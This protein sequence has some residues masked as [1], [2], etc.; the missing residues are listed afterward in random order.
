MVAVAS[1][2]QSAIVSN[3]RNCKVSWNLAVRENHNF[4]S[5]KNHHYVNYVIMTQPLLPPFLFSTIS[6]HENSSYRGLRMALTNMKW[7]GGF[8]G[9]LVG[10]TIWHFWKSQFWTTLCCQKFQF[11]QKIC[12]IWI[13]KRIAWIGPSVLLHWHQKSDA[14]QQRDSKGQISSL[15]KLS[16]GPCILTVGSVNNSTMRY[17]FFCQFYNYKHCWR[18]YVFKTILS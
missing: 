3:C 4:S 2:W 16:R 7:P 10:S 17:V 1:K 8:Q 11:G 18:K 5:D 13:L 6:S 15:T 9:F 12:K 14:N